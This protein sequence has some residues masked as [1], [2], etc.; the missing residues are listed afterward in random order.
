MSAWMIR[1]TPRFLIC[2]YKQPSG[3]ISNYGR[4][5][6]GI[7]VSRA[8]HHWAQT[9]KRQNESRVVRLVNNPYLSHHRAQD[10]VTG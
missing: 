5:V 4:H 2:A 7:Y 10:I 8:V 6:Y 9:N 3:F 1:A